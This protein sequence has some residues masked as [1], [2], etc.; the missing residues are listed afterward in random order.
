MNFYSLRCLDIVFRTIK[1][2]IAPAAAA[3]ATEKILSTGDK[4]ESKQ[5]KLYCFCHFHF[6]SSQLVQSVVC[7]CL[8]ACFPPIVVWMRYLIVYLLALVNA[9]NILHISCASIYRTAE[10][11]VLQCYWMSVRLCW[12]A[13]TKCFFRFL[14]C[15]CLW[16]ELR[17]GKC[18]HDDI[19]ISLPDKWQPYTH[20]LKIVIFSCITR[21]LDASFLFLL[22]VQR[23]GIYVDGVVVEVCM[24]LCFNCEIIFILYLLHKSERSTH[25]LASA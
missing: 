14:M 9:T 1:V 2:R 15:A 24:C 19:N 21:W 3:R 23:I 8:R 4:I 16:N 10:Y 17:N 11:G 18:A 20:V 7:M 13:S 12:L 25:N 5:V 6:H 22:F